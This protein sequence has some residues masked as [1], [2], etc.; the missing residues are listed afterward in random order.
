MLSILL[1]PHPLLRKISE[2]I[3]AD[4]VFSTEIQNLLKEMKK[5]M[6]KEN[7]VGLAAPQVGVCKRLILVETEKGPEAFINPKIISVS[8]SKTESEE[9][10]LS[11]PNVF[12]IVERFKKIKIKALDAQGQK[13][14]FTATGLQ[15][16]IFQHEIDHL[17]G[18]LF[19]DKTI[20]FTERKQPL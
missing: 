6:K 16:I 2:P 14:Q 7:G 17:N 1:H 19:L 18:I 13:Q 10:C 5:T 20:R 3:R 9:G 15:A 4:L 8:G 11:V 12:G